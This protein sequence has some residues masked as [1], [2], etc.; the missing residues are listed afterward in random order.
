MSK[1]AILLGFTYKDST[2]KLPGIYYDLNR[3]YQYCIKRGFK[4]FLLTDI[5]SDINKTD[6]FKLYK[7]L[8]MNNIEIYNLIYT[9]KSNNSYFFINNE[10]DLITK[11]KNITKINKDSKI[12]FYYTG[13]GF[14]MEDN[15]YLDLPNNNN[16]DFNIVRDIL[17]KYNELIIFLDCCYSDSIELPYWFDDINFKYKKT[18][19]SS[20]NSIICINS[21][22]INN[23][24]VATTVGSK[25]SNRLL[26]SILENI[27]INEIYNDMKKLNVG[28][29]TNRPDVKSIPDWFICKSLKFELDTKAKYIK[30]IR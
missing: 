4:T 27:K 16:C 10:E 18:L 7:N 17:T 24:A 21:N 23:K 13:H 22:N 5:V 12:F 26:D 30:I 29:Y 1:I 2:K 19:F 6:T 8:N 14:K 3:Y 15:F 25:L 11:I 9:N 20:K 28:I